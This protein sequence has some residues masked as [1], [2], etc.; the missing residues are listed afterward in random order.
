MSTYVLVHGAWHGGWC[1]EKVVPLLQKQGHTVVAPDLPAHGKDKTPIAEVSLQSYA[2]RVCDILDAQPEPAILVGH[3]MGGM[4]IT[5]AAEYRPDRIRTLV[6]LCAF[7]PRNGESL[8]QLAQTDTEGLVLP[9][10]VPADDQQSA[11]VRDEA[12]KDAFYGDCSDEDVARAKSLLVAQPLAPLATPVST[13]EAN[14]GRAPRV[15]IE[16]LK[17]RAIPPP[18]QKQ[19]YTA[20]PCRKVISMD[21]SHSPFLSAPDKLVEHLTS[22]PV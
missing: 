22:L 14:F 12:I 16:C 20:S 6:Y 7:L 1:W 10:L 5:Q 11:T 21:T 3:S 19:M 9:N 17:D 18:L 15:Y 8:L 4:V 13:T 2:D